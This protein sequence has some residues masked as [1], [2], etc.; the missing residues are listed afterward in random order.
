M[1]RAW[2][3]IASPA[4]WT[5]LPLA[6]I[7]NPSST[8]GPLG[9]VGGLYA[10]SADASGRHVFAVGS[11]SVALFTGSGSTTA[12]SVSGATASATI[13]N[14]QVAGGAILYS[15]NSGVS[16]IVQTAPV[17]QGYFYA[18]N[19]VAVLRG[20]I[21]FAAGGHPLGT[22]GQPS[23]VTNAADYVNANGIIIATVNGGFSW[24]VQVCF[25]RVLDKVCL[26]N[27]GVCPP[28]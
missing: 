19:T 11:P 15:G 25:F 20:T 8:A 7:V 23:S 26:F 4:Q 9:P 10:I 3:T 14:G 12:G 17:M 27:F 6:T 2:L 24:I 22:Q 1:Q 16:F 5:A 21:A 13:T 28:D 18:L